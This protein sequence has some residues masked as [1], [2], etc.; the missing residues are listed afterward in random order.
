MKRA[1]MLMAAWALVLSLI[2]V[3]GC[4]SKDTE[5]QAAKNTGEQI[6]VHDCDGNCGMKDVPLTQLTELN[7]KYYCSGCVAKMNTKGKDDH[8]GHSH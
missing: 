4:G 8:E 6:A 1:M 5:V 2:L 3:T 7:G